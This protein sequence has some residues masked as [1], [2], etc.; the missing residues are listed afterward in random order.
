MKRSSKRRA[1]HVFAPLFCLSVSTTSLAWEN[2]VIAV[3]DC[4]PHLL[5]YGGITQPL[6]QH[7]TC[8]AGYV[9]STVTTTPAS[10]KLFLTTSNAP[11]G[12]Y[13]ADSGISD[14]A[15]VIPQEAVA[16]PSNLSMAT[17]MGKNRNCPSR[18]MR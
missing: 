2:T 18:S 10:S 14:T 17:S 7:S 15:R 11:K 16:Q 12:L 9:R 3:A 4:D 5:T 13:H 8:D 1:F 6:Y